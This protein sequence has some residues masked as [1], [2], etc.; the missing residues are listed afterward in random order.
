MYVNYNSIRLREKSH[1]WGNFVGSL[2]TSFKQFSLQ[3]NLV[4]WEASA[5]TPTC[6]FA[7]CP[8]T[9]LIWKSCALSTP[10]A[11]ACA[12]TCKHCSV[13]DITLVLWLPCWKILLQKGPT[14]LWQSH[15]VLGFVVFYFLSEQRLDICPRQGEFFSAAPLFQKPKK[16][17]KDIICPQ[18]RAIQRRL[19]HS[20]ILHLTAT[21]TP[22]NLVS[23]TP[24]QK[25]SV[26]VL[27]NL[28]TYL[29]PC[30][31]EESPPLH[32]QRS[33]TQA[34]DTRKNFTEGSFSTP[35]PKPYL[36]SRSLERVYCVAALTSDKWKMSAGG[37]GRAWIHLL[38]E[39]G[40]SRI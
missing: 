6:Q 40:G 20:Q 37:W 28:V 34:A 16:L 30:S 15:W 26:S 14:L 23:R 2:T 29:G 36:G 24:R 3:L 12:T 4:Q 33:F 19:Q 31:Q 18:T 10:Q 1:K 39:A 21:P 9:A 7:S 8:I 11:Q 22:R 27:P 35:N 5:M 13:N 17:V 32:F 25:D 38:T